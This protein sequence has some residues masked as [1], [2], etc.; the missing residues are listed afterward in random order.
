M[1]VTQFTK[2]QWVGGIPGYTPK[3]AG[4][5]LIGT[6]PHPQGRAAGVGQGRV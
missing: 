6:P 4:N 1:Q 5:T 2:R 3:V